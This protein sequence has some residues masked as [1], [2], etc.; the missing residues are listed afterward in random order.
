MKSRFPGYDV[1]PESLIKPTEEVLYTKIKN[2]LWQML[3]CPSYKDL[4]A[5]IERSKGEDKK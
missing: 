3:H 1:F 5:L 4:I 2:P